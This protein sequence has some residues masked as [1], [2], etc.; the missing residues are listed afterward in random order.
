MTA[1]AEHLG[2]D[3]EG[4]LMTVFPDALDCGGGEWLILCP[5]HDDHHPSCAVNTV[6]GLFNCRSCSAGG[7]ITALAKG[8]GIRPRAQGGAALA[9][10]RRLAERTEVADP[11]LPMS[12]LDQFSPDNGYWT[13]IRG[14]RPATVRRYRLGLD[15]LNRQ[16]VIPVIW[17]NQLW[18]VIRRQLRPQARPKYLFPKGLPR[19]ELLWG[20]DQAAKAPRRPAERLRF[21]SAPVVLTEG[22]I[23]AMAASETGYRAVALGGNRMTTEQRTWLWRLQPTAVLIGLD[24]DDAGRGVPHAQD[25]APTGVHR[26]ASMM[27]SVPIFVV[28]W[29]KEYKDAAAIRDLDVRKE[30][31]DAAQPYRLWRKALR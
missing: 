30:A 16:A 23:D 31:I 11:T 21:G 9:L 3:W 29:G 1:V 25:R 6:K 18:G 4:W 28:R 22:Q 7:R 27:Q 17:R 8:S 14:L 24:D 10:R 26:V 20:W 12:W 5:F 13:E 15:H 19:R 2:V